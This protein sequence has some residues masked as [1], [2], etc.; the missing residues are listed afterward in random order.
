MKRASSA[1][2]GVV[3]KPYTVFCIPPA[4]AAVQRSASA[5]PRNAAVTTP[6]NA[7]VMVDIRHLSIARN[8]PALDCIEVVDRAERAV[9]SAH[10]DQLPEGW[11]HVARVIDA[12]A[13][14]DRFLPIPFPR[15]AKARMTNRQ[16]WALQRGL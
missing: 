14:Q 12:A 13:L 8:V 11:L 5:T 16:D 10:G 1:S 15:Q 6:G 4:N 9:Q 3:P 2:D 7:S